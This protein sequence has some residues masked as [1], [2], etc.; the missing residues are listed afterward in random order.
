MFLVW[1]DFFVKEQINLCGLF[2][3]K[4][5]LVEEHQWCYLTHSWGDKGVLHIFL[6]GINLK[7]NVIVQLEVEL[8]YFEAAIQHFSHYATESLL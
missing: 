6:K 1:F 3:A 7:V 5:I 4:A 8:A 2:N